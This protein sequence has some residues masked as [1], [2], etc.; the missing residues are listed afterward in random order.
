MGDMLWWLAQN[1]MVAAILAGFVALVCV[2][3]RPRPAVRHALWVL[4]LVKLLTPPLISWPWTAWDIG[5]P[6]LRW[7]TPHN[8]PVAQTVPPNEPVVPAGFDAQPPQTEGE[9]VLV[10]VNPQEESLPAT[11]ELDPTK[12]LLQSSDSEEPGGHK[13]R[14]SDIQETASLTIVSLGTKVWLMGTVVMGLWQAW[15]IGR[16]HR[17]LLKALP[18][19]EWLASEVADLA[20]LLHI[21]TPRIA[22]LPG[23]ASPLVWSLGA[24]VLVWPAELSERL[25]GMSRRCVLLHELAHL[26]R[27][28]HW[29]SWL[30]LVGACLYWWNPLFWLVVRQVRENAELACDAWVVDALP[31]ARRS[32]AEALIEVAQIMSTKGA[33]VPALGLGNGRRRDFERRLLMIMSAGVPC[34]LSWRGLVVLGLLAV[35][36]LPGWSSGQQETE[37]PKPTAPVAVPPPAAPLAPTAAPAVAEVPDPLGPPGIAA[38]YGYP[39]PAA[40]P[41]DSDARLKAIEQQLEALL[42]EV[43]GMRKGGARKA[44]TQPAPSPSVYV[45]PVVAVPSTAAAAGQ[46][47]F[48]T[49][50][51]ARPDGAINLTRA[52]YDLP[53]AKAKALS[54][55]LQDSKGPVVEIKAEG[56]KVTVTTTP[57]AQHIVGQLISMLQ[58]KAHRSVTRY[59]YQAVPVTT[60]EAVP[61]RR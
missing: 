2:L 16:F 61:A 25:T 4:V 8:P 48:T 5:Q 30:E 42:K 58:G 11:A 36:A 54:D 43:H 50:V 21:R 56:D 47:A 34:K 39:I 32:F 53:A 59:Q 44:T 37:K 12:P 27:R 60:S 52:V 33:P 19:P 26:R 35:A 45:P 29:V 40:E 14:L 38:D 20:A 7:L 3:A 49:P 24:P 28:D 15:R 1:T 46:G 57:E 17:R 6:V 41:G 18:R 9:I 10:P 13:E 22:V 31:Q 23:D 55:L 51:V